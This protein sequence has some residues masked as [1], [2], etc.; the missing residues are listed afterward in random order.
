MAVE[1]VNTFCDECPAGMFMAAPGVNIACDECVAVGAD[2]SSSRRVRAGRALI[3]EGVDAFHSHELAG[4][5]GWMTK[6]YARAIACTQRERE[7][8]RERRETD[9]QTDTHT[10]FAL[11]E[12]RYM[13]CAV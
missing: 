10:S 1:G 9:R 11:Y 12:L 8:E 7:R 6:I 4:L 5:A 2:L 13:S 3:T